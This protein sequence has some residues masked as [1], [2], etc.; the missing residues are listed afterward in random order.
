M[1]RWNTTAMLDI[2][3]KL[4][5]K[6]YKKRRCAKHNNDIHF[7][8]REIDDWLPEGVQSIAEGS[9]TPRHLKRRYFQDEM[10]DQL[11][12]S[13]RILQ[14]ILLKQLKPTLSHVVNPNCLHIYGP[15][16][17]KLATQRIRQVLQEQKPNYII[18][19]DIKSFY[20]SI[21]HYKLLADLR[22]IY[23]DPKLIRM[24]EQIIM[25]PI[26]TPRG[27]KNTVTGIAL[28][29]PLS[30]FFSAIYLKPLDDAF[31][32]MDVT[33]IR[34]QDDLI[35]LCKTK[36]QLNRCR[37]RLMEVLQER[38]FTLSRKKSRMGEIAKG[39]HFL[40]IDY[41]GTQPQDNTNVAH[42]MNDDRMALDTAHVSSNYGGEPLNDHVQTEPICIVPHARTIR[43][44]RE[45]VKMMVATGFSTH[46]I[47][48]Y[49][50][51]WARWW[52]KTV[53]IWDIE[54]LFTQFIKTCWQIPLVAI[55]ESLRQ[56]ERTTLL[57]KTSPLVG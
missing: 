56:Q 36:R 47:R 28:R 22:K 33:Y 25:N 52:V 15:S 42:K 35:I 41:L 55:A 23:D 44:A 38:Q 7:L 37:R 21:P 20:K 18:R 27:Y 10:V 57:N 51:H 54:A 9:Y 26:E 39:F 48:K 46:R 24:F 2:G 17:V 50:K 8:A 31:D 19:A 13:D 29:G 1:K 14:H 49:L 30:Q 45:Q 16:G 53:E 11:H 4:F 43:K 6:I 40:G 32:R 3:R 12:L 5:A 34:Y